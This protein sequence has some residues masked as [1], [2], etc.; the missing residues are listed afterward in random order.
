MPYNNVAI[1]VSE[2][3]PHEELRISVTPYSAEEVIR[4]FLSLYANLDFEEELG[5]IGVGRFNFF[6]RRKYLREFRALCIALWG[7][8]LQKSFPNQA[9]I[10]FAALRESAW[11]LADGSSRAKKLAARVDVYVELLDAKKDADFLP[12]AEYMAGIMSVKPSMFARLRLIL[13]LRVRNLYT[14]IFD[15]LV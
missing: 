9:A 15:K 5:R 4:Q 8:A 14:L 11:I 12:V 7:L 13:S 3:A 6:Q 2:F 1:D 10:F